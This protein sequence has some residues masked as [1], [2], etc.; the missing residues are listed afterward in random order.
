MKVKELIS[1]LNDCN[2]DADVIICYEHCGKGKKPQCY[3][4]QVEIRLKVDI[5]YQQKFKN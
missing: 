5:G 2:Q 3:Y 4:K 1:I